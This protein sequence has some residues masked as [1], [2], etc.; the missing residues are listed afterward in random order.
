MWIDNGW[1]NKSGTMYGLKF[2]GVDKG[3]GVLVAG[4]E[5]GDMW[6][7][8]IFK[9]STGDGAKVRGVGDL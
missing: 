7:V 5:E 8:A 4:K 1:Y 6:M 9:S 3:E 2:E